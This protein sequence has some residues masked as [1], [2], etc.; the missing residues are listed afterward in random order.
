VVLDFDFS[1][2]Q[3]FVSQRGVSVGLDASLSVK[4]HLDYEIYYSIKMID[5]KARVITNFTMI[6]SEYF[7]Y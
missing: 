3:L 1:T 5:F 4:C 6:T 2:Q 7:D